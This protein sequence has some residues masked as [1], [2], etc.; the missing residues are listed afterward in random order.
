MVCLDAVERGV[1]HDYGRGHAPQEPFGFHQ[2]R[3]GRAQSQGKG[4]RQGFFLRQASESEENRVPEGREGGE[5]REFVG[6]EGLRV[7]GQEEP[8]LHGDSAVH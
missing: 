6:G 2:D 4:P 1:Q 7:Q 3:A 5:V 8:G